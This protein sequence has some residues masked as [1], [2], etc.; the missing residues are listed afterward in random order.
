MYLQ[1]KQEEIKSISNSI[2]PD[3]YVE[4]VCEIATSLMQEKLSDRYVCY[5]N[6]DTTDQLY[7][8]E[9]QNI[10]NEM[11]DTAEEIVSLCGIKSRGGM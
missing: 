10:F 7:T 4:L 9:G 5:V 11:I 2:E 8:N 3:T 1:E 6:E